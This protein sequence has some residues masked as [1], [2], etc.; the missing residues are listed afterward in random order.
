MNSKRY[1]W[2][3]WIKNSDKLEKDF[4][5]YLKKEFIKV[6][7]EQKFLSLSH[8]KKAEYNLKFVNF[9]LENNKFSDWAI[10][11]CYYTIYHCALALLAKK[12]YS[13]KKHNSTLCALIKFYYEKSNKGLDEEDLQLISK[14]SLDKQEVSYFVEA[15]QKRELA[16]YGISDEF[17]TNEAKELRKKTIEF[18]NKCREIL[19]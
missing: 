14:S 3:I 4:N 13:S 11:G 17:N 19:E 16:S 10:A 5:F 12:G 18:I 7:K 9:L 2:E 15:K 8:L 6:E 1:N